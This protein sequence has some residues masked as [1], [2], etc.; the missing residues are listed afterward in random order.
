MGP[1]W[2]PLRARSPGKLPVAAGHT[3]TQPG[4]SRRGM[5]IGEI[6]TPENWSADS[7]RTSGRRANGSYPDRM[8]AVSVR[9]PLVETERAVNTNIQ[10]VEVEEKSQC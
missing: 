7:A 9:S 8:H 3:L 2:Y 10:S 5:P 6:P 1:F 4:R